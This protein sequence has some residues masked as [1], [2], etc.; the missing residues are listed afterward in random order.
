MKE[1][2]SIEPQPILQSSGCDGR[3]VTASNHAVPACASSALWRCAMKSTLPR[4]LTGH[5]AFFQLHAA[6]GNAVLLLE[7]PLPTHSRN[8]DLEN[9]RSFY[10]GFEN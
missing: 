2:V 6:N 5:V 3:V 9:R 7:A 4:T 1:G 8:I 10:L